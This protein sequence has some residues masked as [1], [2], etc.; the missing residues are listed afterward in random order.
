ME[1]IALVVGGLDVVRSGGLAMCFVGGMICW[2]VAL[3]LSRAE[4]AVTA[5]AQKV[6]WLGKP[7]ACE[8]DLFETSP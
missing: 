6:V 4:K 1:D 7:I 8:C 3:K 5:A 2:K